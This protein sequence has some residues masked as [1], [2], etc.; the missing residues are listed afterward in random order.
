[1]RFGPDV[2]GLCG[3]QRRP[4]PPILRE[5]LR[6]PEFGLQPLAVDHANSRAE[7]VGVLYQTAGRYA[8]LPD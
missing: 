2:T 3:L 1:M 5:Q 8:E 6:T 7:T 4:G